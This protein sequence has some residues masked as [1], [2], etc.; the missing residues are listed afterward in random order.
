MQQQGK[1]RSTTEGQPKIK[2]DDKHPRT[3]HCN[4]PSKGVNNN[5]I[6]IVSFNVK[7]LLQLPVGIF[8]SEILYFYNQIEL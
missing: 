7:K 2:D 3:V 6:N 4:N 5:N 8:Y 1:A